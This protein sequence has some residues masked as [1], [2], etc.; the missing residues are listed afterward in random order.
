MN[1]IVVDQALRTRLNGLEKHTTFC[2]EAGKPLGLFFPLKDYK[3]ML[4]SLPIPF[5][6][7]EMQTFMNAEGGCTLEEI[8]KRVGRS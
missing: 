3:K 2:D 5:S 4:S 8:W 6:P 1:Q 7:E